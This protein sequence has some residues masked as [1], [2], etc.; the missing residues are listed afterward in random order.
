MK[1]KIRIWLPR[2]SPPVLD[3][4]DEIEDWLHEINIWQCVTDIGEK[5]QGPVVYL[6]L[7]D[8]IRK[9][10]NDIS[11]TDLNMFNELNLFIF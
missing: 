11:V 3:K 8:K 5:K 9:S 10:C 6:S 1:V 4:T 7:P 2:Y